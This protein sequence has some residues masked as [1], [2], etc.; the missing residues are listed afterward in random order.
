VN[1]FVPSGEETASAHGSFLKSRFPNMEIWW[2]QKQLAAN[3]MTM[4]NNKS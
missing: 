3:G 1:G 4:I 2:P